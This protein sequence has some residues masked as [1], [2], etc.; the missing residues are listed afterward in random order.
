MSLIIGTGSNIG[1]KEKNLLTSKKELSKNFNLIQESR[2]YQSEPVDYLDQDIFYNQV[3]EFKLPEKNLMS[4]KDAWATIKEIQSKMGRVKI[5]DKGPRNIDID[6][7]FWG[8]EKIEVKELTIPHKSWKDRSF[9][10]LPLLE[11]PF[12]K[13]IKK[14]FGIPK[15]F[16]SWAKPI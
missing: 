10:V 6:I 9:V 5:I 11:L 15:E 16:K 3:L 4:V 7:L 2:V 14:K 12:S 1:D 8:L 13:D